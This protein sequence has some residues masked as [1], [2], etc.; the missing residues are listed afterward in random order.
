MT[1]PNAIDASVFF[2]GAATGSNPDQT[3]N[4]SVTLDGGKTVGSIVFNN[5]LSTFTNTLAIGTG[6]PLTFDKTDAGP[7][8][9]TTMGFGTGNNT[10]SS[11]M[12]FTDSVE[13]TVGNTTATSAAGSL[14]LTG[15][16]SGPGGFFKF[17]DGLAT[18][19]GNG[20]GGGI[21]TYTGPTVLNGGRM[22]I[23]LVASP[24]ATSSFTIKEGAQ[25]TLIPGGAGGAQ[26]FTFGSGPLNLNGTGATS[27]PFAGVPGAIRN[28][29]QTGFSPT[30]TN[31]VVLES[32]TLIHVQAITGTGSNHTP[33]GSLHPDG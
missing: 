26:T 28:D 27:G 4:R 5:D 19:G 13:A 15:A 33:E 7:A 1:I 14:N 32:N 31:A 3:G 21:K 22:R 17:G 9:I 23:S 20:A 30:I 24:T 8:T 6:G 2:N 18:F 11:T 10:I 25:L 29:R 12:V 16:I